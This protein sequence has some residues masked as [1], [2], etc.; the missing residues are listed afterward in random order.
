MQTRQYITVLT[1]QTV[2]VE[3][4]LGDLQ[5]F[6]Y[7]ATGFFT[8]PRTEFWTQSQTRHPI[9]HHNSPVTSLVLR[10]KTKCKTARHNL[11]LP[12]KKGHLAVKN[13]IVRLL[14]KDG[15]KDTYWVFTS[16]P[17]FS[18]YHCLIVFQFFPPLI[19]R[20]RAVSCVFKIEIGLDWNAELFKSNKKAVRSPGE[21]RN[22]CRW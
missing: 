7:V 18:Q 10:T 20:L 15:D 11:T 8:V 9:I 14:Y 12:S 2:E 19:T 1:A 22:W 21:P 13:V 4:R 6:C 3:L 16:V 5:L 17:A